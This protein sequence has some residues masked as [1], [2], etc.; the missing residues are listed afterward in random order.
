MVP[1]PLA[2]RVAQCLRAYAQQARRHTPAGEAP[3]QLLLSLADR[4]DARASELEHALAPAVP[5]RRPVAQGDE[6]L[7]RPS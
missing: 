7:W 4:L 2:A 5:E 3:E 1:D 6:R